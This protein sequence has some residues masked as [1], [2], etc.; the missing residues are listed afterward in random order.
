MER[1]DSEKSQKELE[2]EIFC[3]QKEIF[4]YIDSN[5][6]EVALVADFTR[7]HDKSKQRVICRLRIGDHLYERKPL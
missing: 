7:S 1:V 6:D 2:H 4:R 3:C 5:D